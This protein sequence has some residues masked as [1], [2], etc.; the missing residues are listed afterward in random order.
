MQDW[1]VYSGQDY[2]D[3]LRQILASRKAKNTSY[4]L[5]AFA[6]DL[7]IVP[8]RMSVVLNRK[9]DLSLRSAKQI[10]QRM[11]FDNI[12]TSYFLALVKAKIQR[13]PEARWEA[14][15][16]ARAIRLREAYR[17]LNSQT[18]ACLNW[19]HFVARFL[20]TMKPLAPS[21]ELVARQLAVSAQEMSVI[22]NQLKQL[23]LLNEDPGGQFNCD[24]CIDF[25][26]GEKSIV[27]QGLHQS[28]LE[29]ALHCLKHE[30]FEQR[31]FRSC[32]FT[33]NRSQYKELQSM[34]VEFM[35]A[36]TDLNETEDEPHDM[37]YALALQLVPLA[38]YPGHSIVLQQ[39]KPR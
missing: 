19:R 37:V 18:L 32:I 10:S 1:N 31:F 6:R 8:G 29:Q 14:L 2:V 35:S 20:L 22:I 16:A 28:L 34:I 3:V 39:R 12:E 5:R 27:I 13:C 21:R 7:G 38:K 23:Q 11:Q 30:D 36:C 26:F 25:D 24:D 4:S 17:H 15:K 9:G 33:L